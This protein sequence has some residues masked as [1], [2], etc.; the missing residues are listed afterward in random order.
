MASGSP[1]AAVDLF[2]DVLG[3]SPSDSA[4]FAGLGEAEMARDDYRAAR[5]ALEQAVRLDPTNES[6]RAQFALC[7]R[8]LALDP[9][10]KG[11]RSAD[12]YERSRQLLRHV[13]SAVEACLPSEKAGAPTTPSARAR[14]LLASS[15]RPPL[16]SE[17][18]DDNIHLAEELWASR[19]S[20]CTGETTD[21]AVLSVL[22]RLGR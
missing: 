6:A 17:A 9:T 2:R 19:P 7:E 8:V 16:M 1:G 20:T 4:A 13:L 14:R 12:R 10:T 11:L 15:R 5:T 18:T 21:P 22:E 3:A